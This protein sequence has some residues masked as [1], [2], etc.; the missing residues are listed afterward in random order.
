MNKL[1]KFT[2]QLYNFSIFEHRKIQVLGTCI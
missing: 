2:H 1:L